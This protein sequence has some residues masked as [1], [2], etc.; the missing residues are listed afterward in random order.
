[1]TVK[2]K[3]AVALI[4]YGVLGL[5]A[6]LTLS[7]ETVRVFDLNVRL[8]TGTLLILGLFVF[9]AALHFWRTRMEQSETCLQA[10]DAEE[11]EPM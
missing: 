8:R 7:D 6:G 4:A 1:M 3:F 10:G 11:R 5:L 2:K 9:R